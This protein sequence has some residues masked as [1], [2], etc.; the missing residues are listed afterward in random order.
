MKQTRVKSVGNGFIIDENGRSLQLIGNLPVK[1]G[2]NVWTD[3][4]VVYGH[5][6][7]RPTVKP[8]FDT[9]GIPV[10]TD[11]LNGYI[12]TKNGQYKQ[13]D[14]GVENDKNNFFL[15]NETNIFENEKVGYLDNI[16][17]DAEISEKENEYF[18][19]GRDK[20][21]T[22]NIFKGLYIVDG[23]IRRFKDKIKSFN[24]YVVKATK[25]KNG[26]FSTQLLKKIDSI[27][28]IN[29][30]FLSLFSS[31]YVSCT[32]STCVTQLLDFRFTDKKGNWEMIVSCFAEGYGW[33]HAIANTPVGTYK[34]AITKNESY[35]GS[36]PYIGATVMHRWRITKTAVSTYEPPS[37]DN[38]PFDLADVDIKNAYFVARISS[39]G[40]VDIL[41]TKFK[42]NEKTFQY[43]SGFHTDSWQ[44]EPRGEGWIF[45][46][47][48]PIDGY[49]TGSFTYII[50]AVYPKNE[51]PPKTA[52]DGA[53]FAGTYVLESW[54]V[55]CVDIVKEYANY[56]VDG[57]EVEQLENFQI[58]LNEGYAAM[59]DGFNLYNVSDGKNTITSEIPSINPSYKIEPFDGD[60]K[61]RT[62]YNG[63]VEYGTTTDDF[64]F[65]CVQ[66][67]ENQNEESADDSPKYHMIP[68]V[69]VGELKNGYLISASGDKYHKGYLYKSDART[70]TLTKLDKKSANIR[71]NEVR[72][73]RRLK[74]K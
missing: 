46:P 61:K 37:G 40:K 43:I 63:V 20:T 65:Y 64:G 28:L 53:V 24:I 74:K 22:Q 73:I 42:Q 11:K 72:R 58:K 23:E 31:R 38:E 29:T 34:I 39:N 71:L 10:L 47:I 45:A 1:E 68:H 52:P 57:E 5:R 44:A 70:H 67:A 50:N 59:T 41:Q 66:N 8:A 15:N 69:C 7:V 14:W 36:E 26:H 25:D 33:V 9:G 4:R 13:K 48:F 51:E 55:N 6:P 49:P 32:L 3:G 12:A 62:T 35:L 19:A 56:T 18:F 54:D 30:A 17:I 60:T 21:Y 2:D 27:D 16:M